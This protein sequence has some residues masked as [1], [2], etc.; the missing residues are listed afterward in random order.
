MAEINSFRDLVAW[1]KAF[2]LTSMIYAATAEF[3]KDERFGL[4]QQLRRATVSVVSN[5]AEGAGRHTRADY[6]RFLDMAK[7]S[8]YEVQT[9][10]LLASEF[11]YLPGSATYEAAEEVERILNGLIRA[12]RK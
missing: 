12:L 11:E 3:P 8:L 1:Q 2:R 5:I 10:L 6:L 7:G 9:Q 4:T